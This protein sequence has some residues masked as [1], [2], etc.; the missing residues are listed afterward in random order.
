MSKLQEYLYDQYALVLL[1]SEIDDILALARQEIELM[2]E[3]DIT[4]LAADYIESNG[5]YGNLYDS[6]RDGVRAALGK[7]R[8]PYPKTMRFTEDPDEFFK[9]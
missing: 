5:C 3:C 6:F 4:D 9:K 2:E 8:N 7:V 1:G